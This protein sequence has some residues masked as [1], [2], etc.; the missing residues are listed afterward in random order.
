MDDKGTTL[1]GIFGI[2]ARDNDQLQAVNSALAAGTRYYLRVVH[3]VGGTNVGGKALAAT[4]YF[5]SFTTV[6]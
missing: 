3:G 2:R 4:V 5:N 1:I 6:S